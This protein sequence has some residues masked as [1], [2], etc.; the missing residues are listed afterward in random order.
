MDRQP[1]TP[2]LPYYPR[3]VQDWASSPKVR[4]MRTFAERGL[5][6]ELLDLQWQE[7][8]LPAEPAA[9]RDA[10]GIGSAREFAAAWPRVEPCFPVG[11]DGRRRNGKLEEVRV[12]V[13]GHA[14]NGRS[15]GRASAA[16]RLSKY[17]TS[18]PLTKPQAKPSRSQG[19]ASAKGVRSILNRKLE[20]KKERGSSTATEYLPSL[21]PTSPNTNIG[22]R[23]RPPSESG[24]EVLIESKARLFYAEYPLKAK[25]DRVLPA[26]LWT[27][28][29]QKIAKTR[30]GVEAFSVDVQLGLAFAIS[31]WIRDGKLDENE[32]P[33]ED[34]GRFIPHPASFLRSGE[35]KA[36]IERDALEHGEAT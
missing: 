2:K 8:S 35:W 24:L 9:C 21:E 7:G 28:K 17:G 18:R 20:I 22:S 12:K 23:R 36:A 26:F 19:E 1:P 15:G 5:Y 14:E 31:E 33:T 16:A 10:L 34:K 3:F 6:C 4:A 25:P 27:M 30:E 29:K 13:L 32:R 11:D